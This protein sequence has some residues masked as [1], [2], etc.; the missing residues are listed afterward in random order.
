MSRVVPH[1]ERAWTALAVIAATAGLAS[2]T[3]AAPA[4][5]DW[6]L[7]LH[8]GGAS[9]LTYQERYGAGP[10]HAQSF[11]S[12]SRLRLAA[13]RELAHGFSLRA[14]TGWMPYHHEIPLVQAMGIGSQ[15]EF[16]GPTLGAGASLDA[17]F[18]PVAAGLRYT[19]HRRGFAGVYAEALPAAFWSRWRERGLPSSA[20]GSF[21]MIVPGA[22][23]GFGLTGGM[24]RPAAF[25]LG[26]QWLVSGGTGWRSLGPYGS[27]KF[28]GL[29]GVSA[30]FGLAVRL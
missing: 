8:V 19:R 14:E 5:G 18:V 1:G 16:P 25:E 22:L 6:T 27:E 20:P 28:R 12:T 3:L 24:D 4:A 21:S 29:D 9:G 2:A 10:A 7:A 17:S 13:S 15:Y 11:H 23:V 26:V 30:T